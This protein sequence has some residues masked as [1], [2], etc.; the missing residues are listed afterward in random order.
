MS[1]PN[2]DINASA[3]RPTPPSRW[4]ALARSNKNAATILRASGASAEVVATFTAA[5]SEA[6]GVAAALDELAKA[7]KAL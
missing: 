2:F 4:R 1:E 3:D 5:S 7:K 6:N